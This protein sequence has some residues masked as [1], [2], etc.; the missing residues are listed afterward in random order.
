MFAI[1]EWQKLELWVGDTNNWKLKVEQ[2]CGDKYKANI[3]EFIVCTH[4]LKIYEKINKAKQIIKLNFFTTFIVAQCTKHTKL[5]L[6][7]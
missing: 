2:L 5:Q 6:I 4:Q 1:Q 3:K 7:N